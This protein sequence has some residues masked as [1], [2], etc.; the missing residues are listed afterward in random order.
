MTALPEIRREVGRRSGPP[1]DFDE[2]EAWIEGDGPGAASIP[3]PPRTDHPQSEL[4][5]HVDLAAGE[6]FRCSWR[7]R[8]ADANGDC[9]YVARQ[10]RK[11]GIPLDLALAVL[12][13]PGPHAPA[14][15]PTVAALADGKRSGHSVDGVRLRLVA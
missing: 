8:L 1:A 14:A 6:F 13:M 3:E 5:V 4:A 10:M 2:W 15:R 9:G 7:K 11:A 12:L